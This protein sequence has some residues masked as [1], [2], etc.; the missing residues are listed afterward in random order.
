MHRRPRSWA[1]GGDGGDDVYDF[2]F[3]YSRVHSDGMG[4]LLPSLQ[5][6]MAS[7]VGISFHGRDFGDIMILRVSLL[8]HVSDGDDLCCTT[9]YS[10]LYKEW[11][12][13]L[14]FRS[15]GSIHCEAGVS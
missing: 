2:V 1:L 7:L 11:N 14:H 5:V 3:F 9:V 6:F 10:S 4:G 8:L 12:A 13:G 15:F